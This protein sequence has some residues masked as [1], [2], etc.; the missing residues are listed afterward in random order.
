HRVAA[1][2]FHGGGHLE[3][4]LRAH[5]QAIVE[6]GVG[7]WQRRGRSSACALSLRQYFQRVG[8]G[9]RASAGYSVALRGCGADLPRLAH[10]GELRR[11]KTPA[12]W[13]GETQPGTTQETWVSR[14]LSV[15][16]AEPLPLVTVM[17]R[18]LPFW[19]SS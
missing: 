5:H 10:S 18:L 12:S 9:A 13:P 16:C 14:R 3:G 17:E 4:D 6:L 11:A 8:M 7:I 15:I 1:R 2:L 19:N